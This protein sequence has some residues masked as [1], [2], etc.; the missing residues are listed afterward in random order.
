MFS[1]LVVLR[2]SRRA[3]EE[4]ELKMKLMCV[5]D[6]VCVWVIVSVAAS[7]HRIILLVRK[8]TWKWRHCSHAAGWSRHTLHSKERPQPVYDMW[9]CSKLMQ[10]NYLFLVTKTTYIIIE[11]TLSSKSR[12]NVCGVEKDWAPGLQQRSSLQ[13][14]QPFERGFHNNKLLTWCVNRLL[15]WYVSITT[16]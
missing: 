14:R 7:L 5:C 12:M 10:P 2:L 6:C 13:D 4:R 8:R 11:R 9:V 16:S 1:W 15:T 3:C